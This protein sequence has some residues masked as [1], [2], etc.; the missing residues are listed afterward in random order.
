LGKSPF[1]EGQNDFQS[2]FW[3][4]G[5]IRKAGKMRKEEFSELKIMSFLISI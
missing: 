1:K 4:K 3:E 2:D 5:L